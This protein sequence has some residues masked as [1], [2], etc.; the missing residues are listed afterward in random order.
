MTKLHV[1]Q[2][3]FGFWQLSVEDNDGG[4]R[5]L[6]HHSETQAHVVENAHELVEEGKYPDAVVIVDH[7]RAANQALAADPTGYSTP[8]PRRAGE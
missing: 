8:P 3:N 5:L 4:L 2:D 7:P 6:A 1:T